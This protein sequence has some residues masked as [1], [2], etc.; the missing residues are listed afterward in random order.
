MNGVIIVI[1]ECKN[2]NNEL[3]EHRIQTEEERT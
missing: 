2:N 3:K 1:I